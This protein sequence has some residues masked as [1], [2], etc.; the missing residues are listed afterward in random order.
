[1]IYENCPACGG[2]G[3]YDVTSG[4]ETRHEICDCPAG[5]K[6]AQQVHNVPPFTTSEIELATAEAFAAKDAEIER[7]K[8]LLRDDGDK[9]MTFDPTKPFT[10]RDGRAVT[11]FT[12][13]AEGSYPLVGQVAGDT[14]V[15]VWRKDG[16]RERS[17]PEGVDLINTPVKRKGWIN[18]YRCENGSVFTGH[19]VWETEVAAEGVATTNAIT[20]VRIEWEEPQ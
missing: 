9:E 4:D 1:M 8:S 15:W 16:T 20:T 2:Y 12:A 13:D 3:H 14:N 6:L 10:T 17:G 5:L 18:L 19:D 7:L 11:L